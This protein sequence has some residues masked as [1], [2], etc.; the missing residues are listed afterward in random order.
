MSWDLLPVD[1]RQYQDNMFEKMIGKWMDKFLG[2]APTNRQERLSTVENDVSA[3]AFEQAFSPAAA[4]AHGYIDPDHLKLYNEDQL[5]PALDRLCQHFQATVF[6]KGSFT[7][8]PPQSSVAHQLRHDVESCFWGTHV[9][10]FVCRRTDFAF[11]SLFLSGARLAAS[12][13]PRH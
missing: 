9:F 5:R 11:S 13:N 6:S 2:P 3:K 1:S 12:S 7:R 10:T 8:K 4:Q